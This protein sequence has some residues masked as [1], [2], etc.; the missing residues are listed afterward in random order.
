MNKSIAISVYLVLISSMGMV[1]RHLGSFQGGYIDLIFF[2]LVSLPFGLEN[3]WVFISYSFVFF[4]SM[5]ILR[6]SFL[7]NTFFN[8]LIITNAVLSLLNI[9]LYLISLKSDENLDSK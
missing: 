7:S 6:L 1:L 9:V 4:T 5:G 2:Y 3:K 8:T